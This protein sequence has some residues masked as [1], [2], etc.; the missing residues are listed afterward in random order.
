MKILFVADTYPPHVNGAALATY[1][2]V[3]ELKKRGHHVFVIAPSTDL[4][5]DYS[6]EKGVGVFRIRSVLIQKPQD[7]RVS[8]QLLIY[9][10]AIK[11]ILQIVEPDIV[12]INNPAFMAFAVVPAA[13]RMNIPI[14][15]TSHFMPE[16]I[17]HYLKMPTLI[18]DVVNNIMWK[19]Y[20]NFYSKLDYVISPTQTAGDLLTKN[21]LKSHLKVISNGIDLQKYKR[22]LTPEAAKKYFDLPPDKPVVLFVGR[23]D[24]EK[25]I[26]VLLTALSQLKSKADFH[27]VVAGK[28][29]EMEPLVELAQALGIASQVT[30]MGYLEDADLLKLYQAADIFVMPGVA[31]LQSLVTM[32][33]MATGLPV[34]GANAVAI[35]HLVHDKENGYL[36]SPGSATDLAKNLGILLKDAKLRERM[37]IKSLDIIKNHDMN[38]AIDQVEGVYHDVLRDYK[39]NGHDGTEE[40]GIDIDELIYAGLRRLRDVI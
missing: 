31:E 25:N 5:N 24:K 38:K 11:K 27:G 8:P 37:G 14:V 29:K 10:R 13:R 32:E 33:A 22:K 12:H 16:N 1:R 2:Q 28:G 7:F 40:R 26:D 21:N 17:V 3:M 4:K 19:Q 30:F 23:L 35:P 34:I 36:F 39:T 15:A 18:G 20:A 6:T 9:R